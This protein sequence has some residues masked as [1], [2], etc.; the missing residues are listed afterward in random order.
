MIA[1][2][3][4]LLH[5][6]KVDWRTGLV[7]ACCTGEFRMAGEPA[8]CVP[9]HIKLRNYDYSPVF[10]ECDQI[11]YLRLRVIIAIGSLCFAIAEKL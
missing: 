8:F 9:R 4:H 11:F 3:I 6:V 2:H 1:A 5:L 10:R 7:E